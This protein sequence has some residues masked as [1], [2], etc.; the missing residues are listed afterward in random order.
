[1]LRIG[2]TSYEERD[3]LQ[4]VLAQVIAML[5]E[6]LHTWEKVMTVCQLT[7]QEAKD[8]CEQLDLI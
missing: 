7:A 6:H 2:K 5:P 3:L 8:L 1:M 4:T